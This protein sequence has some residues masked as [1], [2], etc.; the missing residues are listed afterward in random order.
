M[1]AKTSAKWDLEEI[2]WGI[3]MGIKRRLRIIKIKKLFSY[4]LE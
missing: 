4:G 2:T 3:P 1:I